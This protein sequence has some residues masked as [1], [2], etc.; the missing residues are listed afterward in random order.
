M[1]IFE[2]VGELN[3]HSDEYL[4]ELAVAG[5]TASFGELLR[6]WEGRVYR[7]IRR[8]V[9]NREDARDLTQETFSK[10]FLNVS[11]L[12]D[13][14]RFS[15]WLYKIALNECRMRFRREKRAAIVWVD[16]PTVESLEGIQEVPTPE[17]VYSQGEVTERVRSAFF[18]LPE[19]QRVVILM[20]E[21][22][23]LKFHQIAEILD[24]PLSTV[25]SRMY[26]GLKTMKKLM[27]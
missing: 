16:E 23:G 2:K 13:P 15:T 3:A 4:L 11:R 20:K 26:L 27:E 7:F 18:Q 22:Q 17:T 1:R 12:S 14:A 21:Y 25:K 9:G 19:E 10:A 24:L 5:D 8:Y 6:R